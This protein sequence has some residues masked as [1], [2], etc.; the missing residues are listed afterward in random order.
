MKATG[1]MAWHK[2]EEHSI[3]RTEICILVSS[4]WIE[5]MD[6][7]LI[8]TRMVRDTKDNGKTIYR[9]EPVQK[10]LRMAQSMMVSLAM[11]KNMDTAFMNGQMDLNIR[12]I[13]LKIIFMVMENIHGLTEGSIKDNG[14]TICYMGEEFI[15]GQTVGNMMVNIRM[16]KSMDKEFTHGQT[17]KNT[18]EAGET[19][20]NTAKPHSQTQRVKARLDYGKTVTES[21][22]SVLPNPVQM[23]RDSWII[24]IVVRIIQLLSND[25][26]FSYFK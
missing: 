6:M 4:K 7:E 26:Q 20:N 1:E 16:T 2:E 9:M 18:M 8:F 5:L 13:G 12:E 17:A 19:A 23:P 24:S 10:N 11:V 14:K 15:L 3:M 22:G 25:Y 21:N